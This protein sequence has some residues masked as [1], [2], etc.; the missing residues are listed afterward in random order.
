MKKIVYLYLLDSFADWEIGHILSV[1][2]M[3]EDLKKENSK[4]KLKTISNT[5]TVESLGGLKV[6]CDCTLDDI[7]FENMAG[8]ILSGG[9]TW[10]DPKQEK[11]LDIAEDLIKK[12]IMVAGI[13][14]ATLALSKRGILNNHLH[15]SNSIDYLKMSPKYSGTNKYV[16]TLCVSNLNLIT[17]SSAGS[18][19]FTKEIMKQLNLFS[20]DFIENFYNY[21]KTGKLDYYNSMIKIKF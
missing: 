10:E 16:D 9:K 11:I 1:F 17:A 19:E 12:N 8:L 15:T 3:E 21:F 7:D 6:T 13:C 2:K 20:K 18:L 5:K 14:G 4:Y